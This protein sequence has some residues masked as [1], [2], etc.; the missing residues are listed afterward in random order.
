MKCERTFN[1]TPV[2]N[3]IFNWLSRF[4]ARWHETWSWTAI[5]GAGGVSIVSVTKAEPRLSLLKISQNASFC[6]RTPVQRAIFALLFKRTVSAYKHRHDV[7]IVCWVFWMRCCHCYCWWSWQCEKHP[8]N[9]YPHVLIYPEP[10]PF[11]SSGL[12][13]TRTL[14]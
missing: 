12:P 14:F 8:A 2:S 4:A 13:Q 1:T 7:K 6:A 10:V 3:Y 9:L 5:S 11:K